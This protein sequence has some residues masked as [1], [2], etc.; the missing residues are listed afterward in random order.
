MALLK[1]V[2]YLPGQT[3]IT[4]FKFSIHSSPTKGFKKVE[5]KKGQCALLLIDPFLINKETLK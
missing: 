4:N 3:R 2:Y 5:I 1:T